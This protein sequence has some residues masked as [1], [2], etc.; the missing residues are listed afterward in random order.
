MRKQEP[1]ES[2]LHSR[3]ETQLLCKYQYKTMLEL[4]NHKACLT[5]SWVGALLVMFMGSISLAVT[6]NN[7]HYCPV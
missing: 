1:Q 3:C 6:L 2:N 7:Y 5:S 4:L